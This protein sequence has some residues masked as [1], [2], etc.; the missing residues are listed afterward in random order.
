M[1]YNGSSGLRVG[2]DICRMSIGWYDY[3]QDDSVY[4]QDY[5][6]TDDDNPYPATDGMSWSDTPLFLGYNDSSNW[7]YFNIDTSISGEPM[8]DPVDPPV[9]TPLDVSDI[10]SI[11]YSFITVI[12]VLA[13]IALSI[14]S[15][16]RIGK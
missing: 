2:E 7:L 1:V 9:T 12:F 8:A 11:V 5:D 13:L 15:L 10:A 16:K 14:N 6:M 4:M 3:D